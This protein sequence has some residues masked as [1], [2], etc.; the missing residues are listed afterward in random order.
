M[1]KFQVT[2]KLE[3]TT[4]TGIV[5][6]E[7]IVTIVIV[8]KLFLYFTYL[9]DVNHTFIGMTVHSCTTHRYLLPAGHP[10]SLT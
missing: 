4:P 10:S 9:R 7:V 8:S 5:R 6:V 3:C 1:S 2:L